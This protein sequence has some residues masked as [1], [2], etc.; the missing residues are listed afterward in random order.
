MYGAN[1][2]CRSRRKQHTP[3]SPRKGNERR[4]DSKKR[5]KVQKGR[6]A[7]SKK[8]IDNSQ[9]KRTV[10]T[11]FIPIQQGARTPFSKKTSSWDKRDSGGGDLTENY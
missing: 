5:G 8:I 1:G 2:G 11:R 4:A 3:N 10:A 9:G 6:V 7:G